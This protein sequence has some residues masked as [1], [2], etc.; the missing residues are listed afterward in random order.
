MDG[1]Q[2]L[3]AGEYAPRLRGKGGQQL[4]LRGRELFDVP[5]RGGNLQP[6]RVQYEV[7]GADDFAGRG[8]VVEAAED[9]SYAGHQLFW[10]K[11]LRDVV[12]RAEL[13]ADQ[14]VALIGASG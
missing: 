12:V 2:Q 5:F 10:A 13:Q 9:D 11:R 7:R 6:L 8:H 14:L 4:K 3:R 1:L